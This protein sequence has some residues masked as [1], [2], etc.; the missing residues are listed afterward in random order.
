MFFVITQSRES[1]TNTTTLIQAYIPNIFQYL[2]ILFCP[3]C[4]RCSKWLV[5]VRRAIVVRR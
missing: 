3:I 2:M 4:E 5:Y 1:E